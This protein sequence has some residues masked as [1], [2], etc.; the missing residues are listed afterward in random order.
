LLEHENEA[1]PQTVT[2]L[3]PENLPGELFFRNFVD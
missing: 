1:L 3:S 2:D